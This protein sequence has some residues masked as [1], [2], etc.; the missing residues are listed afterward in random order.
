MVAV[1]RHDSASNQW[2]P[3][4]EL[5]PFDAAPAYGGAVTAFGEWQPVGWEVVARLAGAAVLGGQLP[6]M[7]R[8]LHRFRDLRGQ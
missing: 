2:R 8:L 4:G 1:F 5:R 7:P 3:Q 6:E